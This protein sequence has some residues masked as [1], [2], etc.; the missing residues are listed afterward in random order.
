MI[1]APAL[2]AALLSTGALSV[3]LTP[4]RALAASGEPVL[5][6]VTADAP[7][8]A[9][10]NVG[11]LGAPRAA[12][13]NHFRL[14]FTPPKERY[15]QVALIRL[16]S[17]T[18]STWVAL[19][20]DGSET[21]TLESTKPRAKVEVT[22]GERT[23]GPVVAGAKGEVEI[24]V[25][26]P[27]GI[28]SARVRSVDRLGNQKVKT[29]DLTPPPFPL[30]RLA[31]PTGA[32]ASWADAQPLAVEVFA[33]D[34]SG[35][36]ASAP[37]ALKVDH[38]AVG[39]PVSPSVPVSVATPGAVPGLFIATF[40]APEQLP[41][42]RL[43]TVT[44][45][46]AG[47]E[48][49]VVPLRAGPPAHIA[50]AVQPSRYIAG[51][52]QKIAVSARAEDARGNAA[53]STTAVRFTADLGALETSGAQASLSLPDAFGG[54]DAAEVT[55]TAG[56]AQGKAQVEL[57]AGPPASAKAEL[58]QAM[59]RAGDPPFGGTL[60]LRDA[61]G[62]PLRG[63]SPAVSCTVGRVELTK[64]LGQGAYQ[65]RFGA[66]EGDRTGPGKL[67]A[68]AGGGP[69]L[70]AGD[71]L[72]L[73]A[74]AD[75]GVSL[76]I[77][78]GAQSNLAKL[79]GGGGLAE[80]AVRPVG[81]WPLEVMVE[82]GGALLVPVDQGYPEAGPN[83]RI[84]TDLH[85]ATGALGARASFGLNPALAVYGAVSGGAQYTWATYHVSGGGA[86]TLSLSDAG[87]APFA[88]AAAGVTYRAG[89]GR[90]L[91]ELQVT[92]APPPSATALGGNLGQL[93]AM[94][95]YLVEVR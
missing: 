91:G 23:F 62:N 95:G 35:A 43:A 29:V 30:A 25:V 63:A 38:G 8:R 42:N 12:G 64:E 54:R 70:P 88:R 77:R 66:G 81:R 32:V 51:S 79:H 10:T 31:I 82:A 85:W 67:L 48:P 76:G 33:V 44:A 19:P 7:V 61:F 24:K 36:P 69:E 45:A 16:E 65:L 17:S 60:V 9:T 68:S 15:P 26:V 75:F 84:S 14:A 13:P 6:D 28:D 74:P 40:R 39:T 83:A 59:A 80:I 27:P 92:Y 5:L 50:V 78:A 86:P 57:R 49:L 21:L 93:T 11:S 72:V 47:A 53:D 71:V 94:A 87:L 4:A 2:A 56:D 58:A 52:R 89:P 37:P 73:P 22:I 20:V 55:A 34:V 90:V 1:A 3:K 41:P 46:A 18:E